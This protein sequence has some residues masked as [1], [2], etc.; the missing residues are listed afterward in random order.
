MRQTGL[1]L[2]K[3]TLLAVSFVSCSKSMSNFEMVPV[4]GDIYANSINGQTKTD[5]SSNLYF[6]DEEKIAAFVNTMRP[7]VVVDNMY[8]IYDEDKLCEF[9]ARLI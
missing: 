2:L 8:A 5:F 3:M 7:G 1:F 4:E 6:L 9:L